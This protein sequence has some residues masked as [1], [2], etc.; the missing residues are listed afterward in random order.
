MVGSASL[1]L[2]DGTPVNNGDTVRE[3]RL[4]LV[5]SVSDLTSL[6]MQVSTN[7]TF[8]GIAWEPYSASKVID[9]PSSGTPTIA[10]R[11]RDQAGHVVTLLAGIN[12]SIDTVAPLGTVSRTSPAVTNATTVTLALSANETSEAQVSDDAA[13]SGAVW[14]PTAGT[15]YILSAGDGLRR[16][17]ERLQRGGVHPVDHACGG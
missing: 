1:E 6:E 2:I 5:S 3:S 17:E 10:A 16:D 13:F 11:V 12:V 9:L 4:R 15:T 7:G 14:F 8:S